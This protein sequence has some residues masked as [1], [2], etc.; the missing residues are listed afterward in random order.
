LALRRHKLE[1][2]G[3]IPLSFETGLTSHNAGRAGDSSRNTGGDSHNAGSRAG[4]SNLQ[5]ESVGAKPYRYWGLLD[6][7]VAVSVQRKFTD[8][9]PQTKGRT[10]RKSYITS[11]FAGAL[12]LA[13]GTAALAVTGEFSNSA[14]LATVLWKTKAQTE[15]SS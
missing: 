13:L 8:S 7:S 3:E 5:N 6:C 14:P 11:A 4:D 1:D 15:H 12:F 9:S 2:E 10:M